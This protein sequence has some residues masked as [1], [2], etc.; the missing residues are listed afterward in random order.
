[1]GCSLPPRP[2]ALLV[3]GVTF[4]RTRYGS[5]ISYVL[6][7]FIKRGGY[8]E[9]RRSYKSDIFW[10][11][12]FLWRPRFDGRVR[13]FSPIAKRRWWMFGFPRLVFK[14]AVIYGRDDRPEWDGS[15][16]KNRIGL[17][18]CEQNLKQKALRGLL[19]LIR[20]DLR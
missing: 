5:C 6:I 16:W 9:F 18:P 12:H 7:R 8:I 17:E 4:K 20:H 2:N 19:H 10:W 15:R 11:P 13:H 3:E 14:G 1:M